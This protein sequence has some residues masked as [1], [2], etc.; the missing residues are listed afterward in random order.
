MPKKISKIVLGTANFQSKYGIANTGRFHPNE[1]KEILN[2]LKKNRI[3]AI[4]TA[5]IYKN[6]DNLL[7]NFKLKNFKIYSKI[8]KYTG[9]PADFSK[10]CTK[11]IVNYRK[12]LKIKNFEGI[13]FHHPE[14]LLSNSGEQLY[15][16]FVKFKKQKYIK[17]IGISTYDYSLTKKIQKKFKMDMVQIPCNVFDRRFLNLKKEK[18]F[19]NVEIQARSI[20]LQGL[21]ITNNKNILNKFRNKKIFK[22]FNSW[23]EKKNIT[24]LQCCI[25]FILSQKNIDRII[26][27]VINSNELK[28]ILKNLKNFSKNYPKNIYS[29]NLKIIDPRKWT[30]EKSY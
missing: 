16:S 24:K 15:K 13:F 27:G 20:L 18:L 12:K 26:L 5:I 30:N 25:N 2:I 1:L 7:S 19:R 22:K 11:I 17:K 8:P 4:D 28:E 23:C 6:V 29:N 10:W 3:T 14:D 9:K 21:L